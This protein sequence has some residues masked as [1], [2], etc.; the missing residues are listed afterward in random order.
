MFNVEIIGATRRR[1]RPH[2]STPPVDGLGTVWPPQRGQARPNP[3]CSGENL[4]RAVQSNC[5]L[6]C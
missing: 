2:L 4:W 3:P 5:K 6:R 1:N